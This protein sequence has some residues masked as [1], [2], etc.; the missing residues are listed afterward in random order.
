VAI[1]SELLTRKYG[2][3]AEEAR[4]FAGYI[5][6]STTRMQSLLKGILD[7][8]R[9]SSLVEGSASCRADDALKTALQQLE[10]QITESGATVTYDD[11][12]AVA[13][14]KPH[15][16]QVF[17]HLVGNAIKYR[18]SRRPEIEISAQFQ[19]QRFRF[20]VA[21]NGIGIPA[22][23]A[24]QIFGMFRRLHREEYPG[25]GVGLAICKRIVERH[26]GKIWLHSVPGVGTTFHFTLPASEAIPGN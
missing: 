10:E 1:Y 9:V 4:R 21:D 8:S 19:G 24:K 17:Q 13:C 15:L 12:P 26:G 14:P 7:F 5:V 16:A 11:L 20:A 18:G 6:N 22:E 25:I 2:G 3:A 23:Y